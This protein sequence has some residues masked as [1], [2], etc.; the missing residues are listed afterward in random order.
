MG[1]ISAKDTPTV[2]GCVTVLALSFCLINLGIDLIYALID[3][4]IKAQYRLQSMKK[5]K[6]AR[7]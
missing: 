7:R 3:P 2:L 6:P 5:M 1:T 4:R